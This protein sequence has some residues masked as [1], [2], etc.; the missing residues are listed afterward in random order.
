MKFPTKLY[1]EMRNWY[2]TFAPIYNQ[3]HRIRTFIDVYGVDAT[4]SRD[5]KV[6]KFLSASAHTSS[7]LL[8]C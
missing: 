2:I 3:G 1:N 7:N 5:A 6:D 4:K 8:I